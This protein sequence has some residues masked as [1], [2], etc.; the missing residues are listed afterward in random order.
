MGL[1]ALVVV[2][3]EVVASVVAAVYSAGV[4]AVL[5]LECTVAYS[6][7]K[8]SQGW[9]V[10][11]LWAAS[12]EVDLWHWPDGDRSRCM[13]TLVPG[14]RQCPPS[15][16]SRGDAAGWPGWR[17]VCINHKEPMRPACVCGATWRHCGA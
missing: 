8:G 14:C 12:E 3:E 10:A 13:H 6:A 16:D 1:H 2:M 4:S 5:W 15:S 7:P 17:V 11:G 9:P